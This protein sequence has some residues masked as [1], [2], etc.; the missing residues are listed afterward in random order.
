MTLLPAPGN[1]RQWL[2]SPLAVA[3]ADAPW[4]VVEQYRKA[5]GVS[6]IPAAPVA[7]HTSAGLV[8]LLRLTDLI[9]F[10][11]RGAQQDA[12]AKYIFV[13][14]QLVSGGMLS[15]ERSWTA[16]LQA[17]REQETDTDR[18][19]LRKEKYLW[20][21]FEQGMRVPRNDVE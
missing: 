7:D 15:K 2:K 19:A 5:E 17:C 16:C 13:V 12:R 14:G 8:A 10:A 18:N 9:R 3:K 11:P 6:E 4:W 20:S 1:G 21:V